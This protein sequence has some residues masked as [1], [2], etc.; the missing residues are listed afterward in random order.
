MIERKERGHEFDDM[1]TLQDP[2]VRE[3]LRN[4]RFLKYFKLQ[5]MSKEVLL[6]EHLIGLWDSDEKP[7]QVGSHM[8]EID[9][10]DVY[11]LTRL[12]KRGS[13]IILS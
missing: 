10:K 3:A 7:F 9:I 1:A 8:L 5:Y 6:L 13:P 4:Y 11:F 12:S 2:Q